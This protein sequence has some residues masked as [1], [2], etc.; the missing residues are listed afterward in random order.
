MKELVLKIKFDDEGCYKG[1]GD[2]ISELIEEG[3]KQFLE[4]ELESDGVI[5]EGWSVEVVSS[6]NL[7]NL[8]KQNNM[9]FTLEEKIRTVFNSGNVVKI[10]KVIRTKT[11]QTYYNYIWDIDGTKSRNWFGFETIDECIEDC[12]THLTIN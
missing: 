1:H 11:N 3:I 10:E 6:T 9:E 8:K 5:K 2:D 7:L 4:I 12:L